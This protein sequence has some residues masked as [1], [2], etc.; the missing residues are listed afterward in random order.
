M[1]DGL[2]SIVHKTVDTIDTNTDHYVATHVI[3]VVLK[4][5]LNIQTYYEGGKF[6]ASDNQ[7]IFIP[8]GRYMITDILSENGEFEA[9]FYFVEDSLIDEFLRSAD[10]P[11]TETK[12]SYVMEY[13]DKLRLFTET[14][15]VLYE[16]SKNTHKAM[17]KLK[18]LELLHLF[19]H[20]EQ[21]NNFTQLLHSLRNVTQRDVKEVMELNYDKPLSVEDYAFLTGRS[22]SSFRRDFKRKFGTTPKA[23][24][25]EKRLRK[26]KHL[27]SSTNFSINRI[28]SEVGY[29]NTS[30]FISLFKKLNHETPKQYLIR[31]RMSKVV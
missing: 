22:V 25:L 21:Q 11:K 5:E 8:K 13:S 24:L 16:S 23:W 9:V 1:V 6:T 26:A 18:L 17:T 28:S 4:G 31:E 12:F 29:D 20:S 7:V 2:S 3:S 14:I 19:Y 15:L 27:L 10:K 30:H